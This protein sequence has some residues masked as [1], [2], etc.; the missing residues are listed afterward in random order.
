MTSLAFAEQ[1]DCATRRDA[2]VRPSIPQGDRA[3]NVNLKQPLQAEGRADALVRERLSAQETMPETDKHRV[4]RLA[5]HCQKYRGSVPRLAVQQLLTTII[6]LVA[7]VGAMFATVEHAY[8]VTLLLALPAAGLLVRAFIIQHDCGHGSFFASQTLN[9][10]VGRA[11][12]VLTL[13]P[14]GLWRREHALH[15]ATSGN[16]DRRGAG[17][18]KTMTVA[19]YRK[20]SMLGRVYY[21][22]YRHPAFLFG[23]GV[24]AYFMIIQRLPWLHALTARNA[25]KSVLASNVG[26]I[27]LYA[28]LCYVFGIA[29]VLWVG[30]PIL[31]IAAAAGGWLFFI[32]HQFEETIWEQTEGWDF[33]VA[34]LLGSSYYDLPKILNWFTGNIGLHHIHHLNSLIPNYRLM[35]CLEES[36]EL[37]SINRLTLRESLRCTRLKLWD[38]EQRRL[39]RFDEVSA[40]A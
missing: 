23:I 14:Y 24:P 19:E 38:E 6:P 30:L 20:L 25:W 39:V 17:D 37:Q 8:W 12:S 33:Q 31:H 28:P 11:M 40:A 26:L 13:A 15:H 2:T 1:V 10:V 36:P 32:Q 3:L 29:D 35:R 21:Q 34:A 7:I 27:A 9:D 16:L 22:I 5:A 18:I 4:R